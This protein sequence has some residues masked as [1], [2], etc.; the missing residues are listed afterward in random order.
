VIGD[1]RK[2]PSVLIAPNF[3][4]LEDWA[5]K[6]A[7]EFSSHQ[8]LIHQEKCRAMYEGIVADLNS[9]LAQFERLKRII[10]VPD[11]FGIATGELTPSLKLKRRVVEQKYAREIDEMY[12]HAAPELAVTEHK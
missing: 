6:N 8:N 1:K 4:L 10:L 3:P 12:A 2:Y 11:E 7:I 9:R 5:R